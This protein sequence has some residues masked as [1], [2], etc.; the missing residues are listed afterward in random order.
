MNNNTKESF[1]DA[2][3][4][5]WANEIQSNTDLDLLRKKSK[6][7]LKILNELNTLNNIDL[8][9]HEASEFN[10]DKE[11][12]NDEKEVYIFRR[13]LLGGEG[14]KHNDD[15]TIFVPESVVRQEKLE[16]GDR[17]KFIENG[18]SRGRNTFEKMKDKP[19][20]KN[21]EYSNIVSYEYAIVDYDDSLN[22]FVCKEAYIDNELSPI[23]PGVINLYDVEKFSV[24]VGNLISISRIKDKSIYRIRWVHDDQEIPVSIISKN[25]S[26]Y[27][28]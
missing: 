12:S 23:T 21:I 11:I 25:F 1:F 6:R 15:K 20:E 4:D 7:Y 8:E 16:Q 27:K 19:K 24:I 28:R 18:Q 14:F 9:E 26:Q 13:K 2:I 3:K 22:K 5:E 17:F 10:T